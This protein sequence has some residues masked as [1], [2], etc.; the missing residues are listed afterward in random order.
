M[1]P[2]TVFGD[3]KN[4]IIHCS[5]IIIQTERVI[6]VFTLIGCAEERSASIASDAPSCVGTSYGSL[7]EHTANEKL[8]FMFVEPMIK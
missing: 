1:R 3:E 4:Y 7:F 2:Q 8:G 5:A 6:I